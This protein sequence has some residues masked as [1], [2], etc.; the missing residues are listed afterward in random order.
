MQTAH[1]ALQQDTI[2]NDVEGAT[3]LN[4]AEADHHRVQ[5][6]HAAT[7]SLLETGDHLAGNPDGVQGFMGAGPMAAFPQNFN[8]QLIRVWR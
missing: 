8:N 1:R 7:D 3:P 5:R 4:L 2:S 6:V